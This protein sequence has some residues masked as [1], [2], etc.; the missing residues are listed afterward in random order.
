MFGRQRQESQTEPK[1]PA[2]DPAVVARAQREADALREAARQL[3]EIHPADA[4]YW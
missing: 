1:P 3:P 2:P 4:K